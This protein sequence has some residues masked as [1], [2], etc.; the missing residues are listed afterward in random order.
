MVYLGCTHPQN[1]TDQKRQLSTERG[2][3]CKTK[4]ANACFSIYITHGSSRPLNSAFLLLL[5]LLQVWN[6]LDVLNVLQALIDKSGIVAELE[7]DGG[8]ELSAHEGYIP[9]QSNVLRMLGYFSLVGQ[10]RVS[11]TYDEPSIIQSCNPIRCDMV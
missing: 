2:F 6:I 4:A 8:A 5:L 9:N 11:T 1:F 10:L 3:L 7:R